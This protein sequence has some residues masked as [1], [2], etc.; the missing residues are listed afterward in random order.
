MIKTQLFEDYESHSIYINIDN[1][2]YIDNIKLIPD[3]LSKYHFITTKNYDFIK[4]CI[5][6]I[7]SEYSLFLNCKQKNNDI[8]C[9]EVNIFNYKYNINI[10][11]DI[12]SKTFIIEFININMLEDIFKLIFK[13]IKVYL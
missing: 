13:K 8:Y 6:Q 12:E 10:Y 9:F 5:L 11:K 7:H 2:D 4:L 3:T 1:Y